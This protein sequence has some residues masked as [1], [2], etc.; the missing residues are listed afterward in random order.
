MSEQ[1]DYHS[2]VEHVQGDS[3]PAD[4]FQAAGDV[5]TPPDKVHCVLQTCCGR[6]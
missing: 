6:G 1:K 4:L 2:A 5:G 3:G